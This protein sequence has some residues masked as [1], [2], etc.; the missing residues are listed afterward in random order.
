MQSVEARKRW[1]KSPFISV[2]E[3]LDQHE[4][5]AMLDTGAEFSL[6]SASRL[7]KDMLK[8]LKLPSVVKCRGEMVQVKGQIIRDVQYC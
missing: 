2:T 3:V 4:V 5:V 7:S 8:C 1:P 6:I